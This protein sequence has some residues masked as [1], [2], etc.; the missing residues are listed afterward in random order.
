[1]LKLQ[2][3]C[4]RSFDT[5]RLQM[6][7]SIFIKILPRD[8]QWRY[9]M[10]FCLR[11]GVRA[12]ENAHALRRLLFLRYMNRLI[13][14]KAHVKAFPNGECFSRILKEDGHDG[15]K[16][17]VAFTF[18]CTWF[19][20]RN[21]MKKHSWICC[22]HRRACNFSEHNPELIQLYGRLCWNLTKKFWLSQIGEED[23]VLHMCSE[24]ELHPKEQWSSVCF[25]KV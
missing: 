2:R 6:V 16:P 8:Y 12:W 15:W 19:L 4:P 21:L 7:S 22:M 14:F 25:R 9:F 23:L 11:F 10:N 13:L 17:F 5:W 1:M 20:E 24:I 18:L 3:S